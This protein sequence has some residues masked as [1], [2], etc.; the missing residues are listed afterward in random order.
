MRA[1]AW[2]AIALLT[3]TAAAQAP[4]GNDLG[5]K[6]YGRHCSQCHGERGDGQGP[7]ATHLLPRPRDFTSGKFKIR[8][9]PNGALPTDDDLRNIIR[10]GMPYT[11]MPA[12]PQ[13]SDQEL[14]ALVSHVK[15]FYPGFAE[16][17]QAPQAEPFPPAP[18]FSQASADKGKQ[19][20]ATLGCARCHGDAGRGDGSSAPTL[21]DDAGHP[22]R[23]ANLTER[24]TFRGGAT[25][26]DIFRTLSTG[27]NGTPMPSFKDALKPEERWALTDFIASLSESESPGYGT[28]A[29]AAPLEDEID[30]AKGQALFAQAAPVRFPVVGQIMEPGR[31]FHPA[32]TSVV[33][34]AVYDQSRIAFLVSWDDM[35]ADTTGKNGL[36]LPVPPAE[37]EEQEAAP[38]PA[39]GGDFWGEAA[40]PAAAPKA[41]GGDDFWGEGEAAAAPAAAGSEFSDAVALQLPAQLQAGVAKPYFILGDGANATDVWFLDLATKRVRQFA[42]HGSAAL[43]VQEGGEVEGQASYAQG[44]WSAIFVRDLRSTSGVSFTE[45]QFVPVAFSVWDGAARERGSR[46]GLTQW[47]YVYLPPRQKPSPAGPMA[48]AAAGVLV[49]EG[50]AVMVLRRRQGAGAA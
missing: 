28:L 44:Q 2:V 23:P 30:L 14:T 29:V 27:L 10:R 11:S 49:L 31:A 32:V 26:A 46:R 22:L 43:A 5:L 33:V 9:T 18:A 40:A 7:A 39:A 37:E 34:R 8:T 13:L 24:W 6:L 4:A 19:A 38:A 16:K 48:A 1:F 41:A 12:W 15:T 20:Y 36:D 50:L 3:G 47:A 21:K 17:E 25:R 42:G 45:E 35:Q